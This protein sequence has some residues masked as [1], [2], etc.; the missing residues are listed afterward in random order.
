MR[1]FKTEAAF[2]ANDDTK[3]RNIVAKSILSFVQLLSAIYNLWR[4]SARERFEIH[5]E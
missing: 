5:N 2:L 4:L 3:I 1:K